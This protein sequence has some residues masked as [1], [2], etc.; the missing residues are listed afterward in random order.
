MP[1]QDA[2]G[3]YDLGLNGSYLV[4]RE[5][6]QDVA[7]FWRSMDENAAAIRRR[8]P[9]HSAMSP[10]NG[11]RSGS[12]AGTWTVTCFVPAAGPLPA[13]RTCP[14]NDYRFHRERSPRDWLPARQPCPPR[15]PARRARA[16]GE[17]T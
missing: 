15:E 16:D 3:F 11:W 10:P 7:A 1:H 13:E 14:D 8:D 2:Q 4:V 6:R 17:P 5:L 12:S 9:Q